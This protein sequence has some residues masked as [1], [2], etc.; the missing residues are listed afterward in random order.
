M[1]KHAILFPIPPVHPSFLPA[2]SQL[3]AIV[4]AN[5]ASRGLAGGILRGQT[6]SLLGA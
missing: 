4:S 5:G 1:E 6:S 2:Y 3:V